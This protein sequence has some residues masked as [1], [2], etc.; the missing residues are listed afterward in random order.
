LASAAIIDHVE[1]YDVNGKQLSILAGGTETVQVNLT[2]LAT[3]VYIVKI[4]TENSMGTAR[5]VID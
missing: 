3:G 1:V 4:Y 5:V 2:G